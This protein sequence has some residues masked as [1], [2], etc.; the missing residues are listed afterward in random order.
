MFE[1][2]DKDLEYIIDSDID[3]DLLT[4]EDLDLLESDR[5]N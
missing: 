4:E 2:D 1:T 5:S 3:E